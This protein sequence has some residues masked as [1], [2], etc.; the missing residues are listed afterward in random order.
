MS[1]DAFCREFFLVKRYILVVSL[2]SDVSRIALRKVIST[3]D[4]Y[5]QS[6]HLVNRSSRNDDVHSFTVPYS[7]RFSDIC[8]KRHLCKRH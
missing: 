1:S 7:Q 6:Q 3:R 5:E 8:A 4:Y 2:V